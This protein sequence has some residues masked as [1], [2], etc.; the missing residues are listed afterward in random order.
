M[1]EYTIEITYKESDGQIICNL[2][3]D[4]CSPYT[5]I[6]ILEH[7]TDRIKQGLGDTESEFL[8]PDQEN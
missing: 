4:G 2:H 7:F 3:S 8:F 5:L 1:K 6:G